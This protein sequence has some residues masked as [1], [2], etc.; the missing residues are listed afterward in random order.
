MK[1]SLEKPDGF[2]LA[3]HADFYRGFT[4]GSGMAALDADDFTLS[5][6]ADRTFERV[7]VRLSQSDTKI[8]LE[9][10][11]DCRKQVARIL[12]LEGDAKAWRELGRTNPLVGRLQ[13]EFPGFFTAAKSSPYDAATWAILSQ[14]CPMKLAAKIKIAMGHVLSPTKLV[15]LDRFAGVSDEKIVRLR[16]VAAAA[17][18]G[19]LDADRLRAMPEDDALADLM[20]IRGVGP[21]A[22]SHIYYRGAA[23]I[24][25]LPTAEPRIYEGLAS[26]LGIPTPS[27]SK[28]RDIAESW[29]PFRMWTCIL[30]SRHLAKTGNWKKPG[31]TK[32]RASAGRTLASRVSSSSSLGR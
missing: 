9:S 25:A 17:L 15:D 16:G 11:V 4:P 1:I 31:L 19:R 8:R 3:A 2:D 28:F 13:A 5:F 30:L 10:D 23:P 12:G 26:A 21:W 6:F 24:D 27:E 18:E 7:V 22:A 32:A 14:R 29:R 20:K